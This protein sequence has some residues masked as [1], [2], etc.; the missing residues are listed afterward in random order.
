MNRLPHN[1]A[2]VVRFD[3]SSDIESGIIEGKVEHVASFRTERFQSLDE[4]LM[5]VGLML[6]DARSEEV[7]H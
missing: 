6:R 3:P 1:T 2:F 4:L 5:F 7:E